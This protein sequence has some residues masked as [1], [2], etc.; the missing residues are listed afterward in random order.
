ME[1]NWGSSPCPESSAAP[2][3]CCPRR[4]MFLGILMV[5]ST[6]S[7]WTVLDRLDQIVRGLRVYKCAK[8]NAI[9]LRLEMDCT[10]PLFSESHFWLILQAE[11]STG[12]SLS[13]GTAQMDSDGWLLW[14]WKHPFVTRAQVDLSK[15]RV[16]HF[17]CWIIIF[18]YFSCLL[19]WVTYQ[20]WIKLGNFS[21]T[22]RYYSSICHLQALCQSS[23]WGIAE[24]A[25]GLGYGTGLRL[26]SR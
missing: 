15:N 16:P 21:W 18:P 8:P 1:I 6:I 26:P 22:S 2:R 12:F 14:R 13:L 20:K 5:K 11:G 7:F 17:I 24:M 19:Q 9:S 10:I 23:F 3:I 25:G 4:H